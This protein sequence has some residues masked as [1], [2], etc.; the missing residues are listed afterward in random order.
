MF[1]PVI[2]ISYDSDGNNCLRDEVALAGLRDEVTLTRRVM[3]NGIVQKM[4]V[5]MLNL[6]YSTTPV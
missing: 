3:L 5:T 1:G 2:I 4:L 6:F